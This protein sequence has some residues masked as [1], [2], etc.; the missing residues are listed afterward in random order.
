MIMES[1]TES[2]P[3]LLPKLENLSIENN[4]SQDVVVDRSLELRDALEDLFD[5][6]RSRP[7]FEA[8]ENF[9]S[10]PAMIPFDEQFIILV[11]QYSE[12]DL[13]KAVSMT[14]TFSGGP[15][16]SSCTG[17]LPI[18]LA[19]DNNAPILVIQWLLEAD[20]QKQSI[21]QPDKWGDLPI[22]TAC[23][24]RDVDIVK[25]L[26]D[27]DVNKHTVLVKDNHGNLPL[28]MACRYNAPPQVIQLLL[29][30]DSSKKSLL[31]EG[32]YG[33]LPL[34]VACRCNAPPEMMQAL[35]ESDL[36]KL[37]VAKEDSV[38][39][40]PMHVYFLR[41]TDTDCVRLLLEGMIV[42]RMQ[43][44]GLDKW[45]RDFLGFLKSMA[46]YE[47]DF[48]TRDK[49]D[50]LGEALRGL[51]ERALVLELAVWKASCLSPNSNFASMEEIASCK[52]PGF[53]PCQYKKER[54]TRSG[55]EAIIVGVLPFLE[56]E[57]IDK[58]LEELK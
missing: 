23:S 25:L 12:R 28:H 34:H 8:D 38:G 50:L 48:N 46:T 16:D 35:L 52:E 40:L 10:D 51:M 13:Q 19:C 30:A 55:A 22:H 29:E 54:R 33:Q 36:Q 20:T 5:L 14:T 37:S 11:S 3:A 18:H 26:L 27:S 49:L 2:N 45:K 44:V 17:R 42:H 4:D 53:D 39:R 41:N 9:L 43:R 6:Q 57:S 58:L 47:R 21:L 56:N 32:V 24:R 1:T 7:Y 31:E 15:E